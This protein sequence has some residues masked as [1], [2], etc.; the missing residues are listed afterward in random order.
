MYY[1][2]HV[3]EIGARALGWCA[4]ACCDAW[5]AY[6]AAAC[7]LG[8]PQPLETVAFCDLADA[9]QWVMNRTGL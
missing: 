8:A 5:I 9:R 2:E 1:V 7:L 6:E 4:A 3:G